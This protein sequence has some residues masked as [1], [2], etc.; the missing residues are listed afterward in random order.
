MNAELRW[1]PARF[2]DMAVFYD[3]GKVAGDYR[4]LD[5]KGLKNSYGIGMRLIGLRGYVFRIEAARSREHA[6]LLIFSAGGA[7]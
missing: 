1:T 3:T 5:L 7:F 2:L 6:A 4:D